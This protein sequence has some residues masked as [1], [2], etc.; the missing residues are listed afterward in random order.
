MR[1]RAFG[2]RGA[3]LAPWLA[4][5]L[6]LAG[7]GPALPDHQLVTGLDGRAYRVLGASDVKLRDGSLVLRVDFETKAFDD[8]E[9]SRQEAR[10]LL[11][12]FQNGLAR[13]KH[14]LL[15]ANREL[16]SPWDD[17]REQRA[18]LFERTGGKWEIV[19]ED[20]PALAL[21]RLE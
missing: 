2:W 4:L 5:G 17:A 15:V 12:P 10:A 3:V 9:A 18:F 13:R 11:F 14:A 8:A 19:A 20:A 6:A 21:A 16:R 1:S 7:C